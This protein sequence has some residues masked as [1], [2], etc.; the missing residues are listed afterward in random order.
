MSEPREEPPGPGAPTI[1]LLS[2][3]PRE[4]VSALATALREAGRHAV[5]VSAP[6]TV[7]R[8]DPLFRR[9]A[10]E[11]HVAAVPF[12]RR[13]LRA[14]RPSV[15]Q[16]FTLSDAYAAV[17]EGVPLVLSLTAPVARETVAARRLRFTFLKAALEAAAA[18]TAPDAAVAASAERWLGVTPR[19]LDPPRDATDFIALYDEVAHRP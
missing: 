7:R 13:A 4:D 5:V 12:A 18:I 10:F 14:A 6:A 1:A 3:A 17:R 9:R 16:A 15:A 11:D 2:A 8:L 19:V